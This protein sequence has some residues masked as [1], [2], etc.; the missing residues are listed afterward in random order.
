MSYVWLFYDVADWSMPINTLHIVH[1]LLWLHC[2][3][4]H[5][6]GKEKLLI[7][8]FH[9]SLIFRDPWVCNQFALTIPAT[10][11]TLASA[12]FHFPQERLYDPEKHR[13]WTWL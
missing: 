9:V 13:E 1:S 4:I 11:T 7:R 12:F 2:S 5:L 10:S 3:L 6:G 8:N